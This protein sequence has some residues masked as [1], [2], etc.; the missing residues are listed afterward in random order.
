ME[1]CKEQLKLFFKLVNE[2]QEKLRNQQT[3]K[4]MEQPIMISWNKLKYESLF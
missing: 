3:L 1:K 4:L 2:R